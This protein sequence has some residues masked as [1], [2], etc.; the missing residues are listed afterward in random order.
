MKKRSLKRA[1]KG[2]DALKPKLDKIKA[3]E[4]VFIGGKQL[5]DQPPKDQAKQVSDY[6]EKR[7]LK[8]PILRD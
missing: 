2:L 6:C 3:G 1:V 7:G 5:T 4:W 8:V